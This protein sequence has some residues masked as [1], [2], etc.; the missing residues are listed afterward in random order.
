MSA[1]LLGRFAVL[2]VFPLCVSCSPEPEGVC[3]VA[4]NVLNACE[5]LGSSP[6]ELQERLGEPKQYRKETEHRFGFMRW[7][8]I[9]GVRLFVAIREGKAVHVAYGFQGMDS[10]DE[11]EAF[12]LIGVKP[13]MKKPDWEGERGAKRWKPFGKY[14][15]MTVNPYS[16]Y[17]AIGIT[18]MQEMIEGRE[19]DG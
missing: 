15:R 11:V 8:D 3:Q 18:P 19:D 17:V 14:D 9:K 4:E 13:P 12:H 16:K 5:V 1:K 10:F 7:P 6:E 2:A